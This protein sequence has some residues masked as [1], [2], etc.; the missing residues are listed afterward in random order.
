MGLFMFL[1]LADWDRTLCSSMCLLSQAHHMLETHAW[2]VSG[3]LHVGEVCVSC[4]WHTAV[5]R[6]T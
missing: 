1:C 4:H 5:C 2:S 3:G 6:V